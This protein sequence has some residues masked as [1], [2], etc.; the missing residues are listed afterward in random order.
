MLPPLWQNNG[1]NFG[2]CRQA[3]NLAAH[4]ACPF[5][6]TCAATSPFH[7][8]YSL[9]SFSFFPSLLCVW[10]GGLFGVYFVSALKGVRGRSRDAEHKEVDVGSWKRADLS[11]LRPGIGALRQL[12]PGCC[13]TGKIQGVGDKSCPK[14]PFPRRS[15]FPGLKQC[16]EQT[17]MW[18]RR[19]AQRDESF[20]LM[21]R[22]MQ[23]MP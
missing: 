15:L 18:G 21:D 8:T 10:C 13:G 12:I 16:C 22:K 19:R 7:I 4:S 11:L 23:K 17:A 3:G 6:F 20:L 2:L 1:I 9:F 5:H 14:Y